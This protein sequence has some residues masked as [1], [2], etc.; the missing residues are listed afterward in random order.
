MTGK[1]AA[2]KNGPAVVMDQLIDP[3]AAPP[4]PACTLVIFGASGDLTHRLLV[5]ALYNLARAGSLDG[6][7]RVVGVSRSPMTDDQFRTELTTSIKARF[8]ESGGE[9]DA[10]A[11]HAA[12][13]PAR[14]EFLRERIHY[15]AADLGDP[16]SYADLGNMIASLNGANGN[17]KAGAKDAIGNVIFYLAIASSLFESTIQQLAASQLLKQTKNGWRR[18]I[19]EK[20]FGHDLAS[21]KALDKTILK[22]LR[23]EQVFRMDHFLGKETVQNIMVLRFANGFFEPL[24]NRQHID[25]VQITASETVGVEGRGSFY[26]ATGAL[27]DMVP[28]HMFQLLAMCAMEAPNSFSADAVRSEKAKVIQ[29]IRALPPREAAGDTVRARYTAGAVQDKFV[30]SYREEPDVK[31]DSNTETYVAMKLMI[32]NWRWADVPFYV[33]TG[34][35]LATRRTEIAIRFKQV[36]Y[37]LF[38]DLPQAT[39]PSN[40]LIL[41]VQPEEGISTNFQAK[42]PGQQLAISG[43]K[44]NF[45]YSD[46]FQ[47][48]ANTGYETLI[49]DCMTGDATL[50]QRADNIEGGWAAVQPILDAWGKGYSPIV[51]YR[52][53]SNGPAAADELLI[54][55][56]R[57][58]RD[59]G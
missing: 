9:F 53:G 18:L 6:G 25:H 57:R 3:V 32:D 30:K 42:V 56:G 40:E 46:Y 22:V 41:H 5:P 19:I 52:A 37:A 49:Y 33:R 4:A 36:P 2:K 34:K 16:A 55:D 7:F 14:W 47:A 35:A 15:L 24:W 11:G 17:G 13:V 12:L 45:R 26:D 58:W 29:A 1:A 50:F 48:Q 27:R 28:N 21:A 23:E 20:P 59:L 44:M 43:V 10:K 39:L 51:D 31:R 38:R 54:R 8:A